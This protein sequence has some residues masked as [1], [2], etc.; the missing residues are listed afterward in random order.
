MI[1]EAARIFKTGFTENLFAI[2][3]IDQNPGLDSLI[4]F[5]GMLFGSRK[6]WWPGKG[7]RPQS[8]EGLDLCFFANHLGNFFRLD[9]TMLIPAICKSIVRAVISDFLGSTVIA[10]GHLDEYGKNVLIFYAHINPDKSIRPG[11]VLQE[12]QVFAAIAPPHEKRLLPPHLHI[13]IGAL[14]RLPPVEDLRWTVLNQVDRKVFADPL[15]VISARHRIIKYDPEMDLYK[16]FAPA[17]KSI[18]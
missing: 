17:G 15:P 14:D 18:S 2:N 12:G 1:M 3:K 4:F 5:E 10:E 16:D 6:K 13:S 8:H 9:E 11:Y 7:L